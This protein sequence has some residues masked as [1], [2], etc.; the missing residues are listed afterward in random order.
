MEI[1]KANANQIMESP[2]FWDRPFDIVSMTLDLYQLNI[3]KIKLFE[4]TIK[5]AEAECRR[6]RLQVTP[7]LNIF[8]RLEEESLKVYSITRR[9]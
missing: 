7:F 6:K 1:I 4:A 2:S 8:E 3:D 9:R 5:W